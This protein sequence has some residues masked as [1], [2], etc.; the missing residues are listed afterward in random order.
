MDKNAASKCVLKIA[1]SEWVNESRDKRELSVINELGATVL[2]MAKGKKTGIIDEVDGFQVYRV[3][4]RPLGNRMPNT[5]NRIV[6]IFTWAWQV[7]K[8]GPQIISGHDI[9]AVFIG[10]LSGLFMCKERK[11]KLVYDSHEFEIGRNT[12]RNKF[13]ILAITYL[14]RFLI[15]KCEFTIVVNDSIADEV[16][17]IHK[18]DKRPIVVRNIPETWEIDTEICKK[19]RQKMLEKLSDSVKILLMYHGSVG[20]RRGIEILLDTIAD[21]KDAGVIILGSCGDKSFKE[22]LIKKAKKLDVLDRILFLHAVPIKEL[23]K[24]VGA[25]DV[26]MMLI[27]PSVK[28]YYYALPNKLFESIQALTPVI[29]SDLPEMKRIIKLY[30][31]GLLSAPSDIQRIIKC[32][33]LMKNDKEKYGFFKENLKIAKRELCWEEEKKILFEVYQDIFVKI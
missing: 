4:T 10:Y 18:L 31:I 33:E 7:R 26:S 2:V 5:I 9:F 1:P 12:K 25:A 30:N 16:Q 6:S 20:E 3:S 17:K 21:I 11:P 22:G 23:W 28:S 27:V 29:A 15:K 24:Y 13:Q 32:V 14:E 8:I 19:Q